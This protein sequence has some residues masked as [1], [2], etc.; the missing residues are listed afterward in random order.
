MKP[1]IDKNMQELAQ[2]LCRPGLLGWFF[3]YP[4]WV[5]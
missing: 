2:V 1:A 5:G 4:L 3:N